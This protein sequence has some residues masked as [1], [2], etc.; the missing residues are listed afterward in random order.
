VGYRVC[1]APKRFKKDNFAPRGPSSAKFLSDARANF[2]L[3]S[4]E[5]ART[6]SIALGTNGTGEAFDTLRRR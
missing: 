4:E 5:H 6:L 2:P 1:T 3:V